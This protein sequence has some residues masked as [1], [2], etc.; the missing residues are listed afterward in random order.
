MAPPLVN[1]ANYLVS[2]G[3]V[4][5]AKMLAERARQ[6]EPLS[7]ISTFVLAVSY[8]N[9]GYL[10]DAETEFERGYDLGPN[11]VTGL[12][13]ALAVGN[14]T[15]AGVPDHSDQRQSALSR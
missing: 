7:A 15:A 6:L 4:K 1:F 12:A 5:E 3:R 9:T 11:R 10:A 8:M 2:V 14:A 13:Y